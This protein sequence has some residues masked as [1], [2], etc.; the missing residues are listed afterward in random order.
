MKRRSCAFTG[1]RPEKF[2]WKDDE[3]DSQC[4]ALKAVL[5]AQIAELAGSGVTDFLSGMARGVDTWTAL[6]VLALRDKNPKIKLRCILPDTTQATQWSDSEQETYHQILKQ[7][8]SIVYVSRESHRNSMMD[9]NR[10]MADHADVLL[11]V[12]SNI[13]ERRGGTAATVRYA[14][15]AG[16]KII[17]LDP[18]TLSAACL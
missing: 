7:A 4:I 1:H 17:L 9:R 3:T 16:K 5:I 10:F 15:K 13:D 2:P 12:C 8:D 18:I 6:A 14:K 11:A